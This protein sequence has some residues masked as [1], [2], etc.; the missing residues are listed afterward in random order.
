MK[1]FGL[2]Y[3]MFLVGMEL[4][5]RKFVKERNFIWYI[6]IPLLPLVITPFVFYQMGYS[7]FLGV[8]VS[9]IS[10]GIVIPVLKES[11][12]IDTPWGRDIIGIALTGEL[13][14]II[15]L[16]GVDIQDR[17]GFT[18][19]AGTESAKLI[20]LFALAALFLRVLFIIAW[21]NPEAVEKVMESEDPVEEGIR[22]VILIAVA[23]ALIAYSSGLEPILGSFIAGLVFSYVFKNKARFEE[24]INALGFGFFTPFFFV[25]IGAD[26]DMDSI[27]SVETLS[28]SLFLTLMVFASNIFPLLF[29]R[30]MKLRAVEGLGMSFIFSA[31]LAMMVVAGTLGTRMGILTESARDSLVLAG[32]ISSIVFPSLFRKIIKAQK[33][34]EPAE[35]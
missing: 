21:W 3:L 34:R 4:D 14:S 12:I 7:F 22:A 31:P 19:R 15:V 32:V 10:A 11:E 23:G 28:L 6:I 9:M 13:L 16:M 33:G 20:L 30:F 24:K 35:A 17:Y 2:I 25:G 27:Q 18:L 1:E 29:F 5:L 8:A 26:L